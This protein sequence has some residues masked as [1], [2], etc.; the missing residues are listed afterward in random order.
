VHDA[1]RPAKHADSQ[2]AVQADQSCYK[3]SPPTSI[4]RQVV[5]QCLVFHLLKN[6]AHSHM[7]CSPCSASLV[8]TCRDQITQTQP[9]KPYLLCSHQPG[10]YLLYSGHLTSTFPD[11]I[12]TA[13]CAA[14]G[15]DQD[16]WTKVQQTSR[17]IQ[18]ALY[19]LCLRLYWHTPTSSCC[20]QELQDQTVHERML[21]CVS[22][23]HSQLQSAPLSGPQ[24]S[25]IAPLLHS[26]FYPSPYMEKCTLLPCKPCASALLT[27][28]PSTNRAS[29]C[30]QTK[31][32]ARHQ[33]RGITLA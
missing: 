20:M 21:M 12:S 30:A 13:V 24:A 7:R 31:L 32:A 3:I 14:A 28:L 29:W 9:A 8:T 19:R 16:N 10:I 23:L 15:A 26:T 22:I 6:F 25:L 4:D 33:R 18:T 5:S 2:V 1:G 27:K 11:A 17:Y